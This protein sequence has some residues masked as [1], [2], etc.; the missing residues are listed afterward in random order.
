MVTEV[1]AG[2]GSE[3]QLL[4]ADDEARAGTTR[5]DQDQGVGLSILYAPPGGDAGTLSVDVGAADRAAIEVRSVDGFTEALNEAAAAALARDPDPDVDDEDLPDPTPA[6]SPGVWEFPVSEDEPLLIYVDD[7]DGGA[8]AVD[9]LTTVRVAALHP[10]KPLRDISVGQ[11][12]EGTVTFPGEPD[13]FL[14]DLATG[15]EVEIAARSAVGD[16]AFSVSPASD[17]N[18]VGDEVDDG[19]GGLFDLDAE[20]V[21]TAPGTGAYVIDV[22][23]VD[24]YS[25]DYRLEVAPA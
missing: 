2:S 25:T 20:D 19:G 4:P 18:A 6:T 8:Q 5:V 23:Q 9:V 11:S 14:L 13:G 15:E 7:P 3:W 17:P 24:G 1:L 22:H 10:V 12:D 16:V 21:F